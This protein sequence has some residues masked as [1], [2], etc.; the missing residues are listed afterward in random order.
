MN[1]FVSYMWVLKDKLVNKIFTLELQPTVKRIDNS[2]D[3]DWFVT[4][5]YTHFYNLSA[6][7]TLI[8]DNIY[9]GNGYNAANPSIIQDNNIQFVVNATIEIPNY[10]ESGS[11][12]SYMNIPISDLDGSSIKNYLEKAY[13]FITHANDI[14][15]GNI[16][17]HCYMG[18]SRSAAVV[19]Y[20][21]M[22]MYGYSLERALEFVKTKRDIVNVN[23]CFIRDLEDVN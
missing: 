9:L 22:K 14:G 21:L 4:K 6:P 15:T 13:T 11:K 5:L 23:T 2:R 10:F 20:Y 18:S 17:V 8:V 3:N 12:V 1:N 16:L 7:P 19:I